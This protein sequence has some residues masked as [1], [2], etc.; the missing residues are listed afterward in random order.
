MKYTNT[1]EGTNLKYRYDVL[2]PKGWRPA[3]IEKAEEKV[4][5][6]SGNEM[7]ELRIVT[8]LTP[9][10]GAAANYYLVAT[11]GSEGRLREVVA[12]CLPN[13]I[14]AWDAKQEVDLQ[15]EMLTGLRVEV[16]WGHEEYNGEQRNRIQAVRRHPQ[17]P[18]ENGGK[19]EWK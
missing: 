3:I 4:S 11:S 6:S 14:A 13:L 1:G 10:S 8:D 5:K 2:A 12:A 15:P 9:D 19:R 17:G 16:L 7:I 18:G